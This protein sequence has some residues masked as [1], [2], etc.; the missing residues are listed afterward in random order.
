LE[1]YNPLE[2]IPYTRFLDSYLLSMKMQ[3][4]FG[5]HNSLSDMSTVGTFDNRCDREFEVAMTDTLGMA[6]TSAQAAFIDCGICNPTGIHPL[7]NYLSTDSKL[8]Q[9]F[10]NPFAE[11]PQIAAILNKQ[12]PIKMAVYSW[13]GEEIK[14]LA[15]ACQAEDEYTVFLNS[16]GIAEGIYYLSLTTLEERELGMMLRVK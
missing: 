9:N 16:S 8:F 15:D 11:I 1:N 12:N 4:G 6:Y 7:A 5:Y 10:P 3:K 2:K 13:L 14:V